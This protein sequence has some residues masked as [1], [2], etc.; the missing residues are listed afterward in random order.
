MRRMQ[1]FRAGCVEISLRRLLLLLLHALLL[2][3]A[4]P[5]VA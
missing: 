3:Q 5:L 2:L 4:R 1:A